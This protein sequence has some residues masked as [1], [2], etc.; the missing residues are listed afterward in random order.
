MKNYFEVSWK[1]SLEDMCVKIM[2]KYLAKKVCFWIPHT[3]LVFLLKS[4]IH[5]S[6]LPVTFFHIYLYIYLK[7]CEQQILFDLMF[8]RCW[9]SHI[10]NDL[11]YVSVLMLWKKSSF[12]SM[13][14]FF[15][16]LTL[17][18]LFIQ[19]GHPFM[20]QPSGKWCSK[21]KKFVNKKGW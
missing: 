16:F 9:F 17:C 15:F 11:C 8:M 3:V 14:I 12:S 20:N 21:K 19:C 10:D 2:C 4:G 1:Y 5:K 7:E 6:L 18:L 13:I